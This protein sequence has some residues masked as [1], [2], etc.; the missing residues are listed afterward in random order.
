MNACILV[1]T[2]YAVACASSP[3][4][5]AQS[6]LEI[7]I[8]RRSEGWF[9]SIPIATTTAPDAGLVARWRCATS[10]VLLGTLFASLRTARYGAVGAASRR[11]CPSALEDCRHWKGACAGNEMVHLAY[12]GLLNRRIGKDLA[13]GQWKLKSFA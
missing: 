7:L 13:A 4:L 9:S 2:R 11:F 3:C 8:G 1:E 5:R 12:V 6:I 10:G